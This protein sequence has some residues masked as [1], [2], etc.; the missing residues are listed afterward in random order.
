MSP[1]LSSDL[2]GNYNSSMSFN[3]AVKEIIELVRKEI[4][5]LPK[6]KSDAYA[7]GAIYALSKICTGEKCGHLTDYNLYDS[8]VLHWKEQ[9]LKW[10]KRYYKEEVAK[11]FLKNSEDAFQTILSAS[12]NGPKDY[13]EKDAAERSISVSFKNQEELQKAKDAAESKHPV[14]LGSALHKYLETCIEKLFNEEGNQV[15]EAKELPNKSELSFL[16]PKV[17]K[18]EKKQVFTLTLETLDILQTEENYNQ[19]ISL[20]GYDLEEAIKGFFTQHHSDILDV[21]DFDSES[22]AFCVTSARIDAVIKVTEVIYKFYE[23]KQLLQ[24][25]L[26]H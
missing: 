22:S 4:E 21:L 8:E 7:P 10:F 2:N 19:D 3:I 5:I 11:E 18:H 14:D 16:E 12:G 26:K 24:Q 17:F 9:Y 25:N 20:T 1:K 6:C 13:W 15:A 23:N